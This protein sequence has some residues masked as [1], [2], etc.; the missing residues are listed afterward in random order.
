MDSALDEDALLACLPTPERLRDLAEGASL[1]LEAP[2]C[3]PIRSARMTLCHLAASVLGA[4]RYETMSDG[5]SRRIYLTRKPTGVTGGDL[6]PMPL[7]MA[8]AVVRATVKREAEDAEAARFKLEARRQRRRE[9]DR[10]REAERVERQAAAR[11]SFKAAASIHAEAVEAAAKVE[12]EARARAAEAA[13]AER[14]RRRR[15]NP[16]PESVRQWEMG[17]AR[18]ILQ[19][20]REHGHRGVVLVVAPSSSLEALRW[21]FQASRPGTVEIMDHGE[22]ARIRQRP[23][24]AALLLWP[25]AAAADGDGFGPFQESLDSSAARLIV[26]RIS[27]GSPTAASLHISRFQDRPPPA[28]LPAQA[29]DTEDDL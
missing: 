25:A 16:A 18:R 19:A 13:A 12:E 28:F 3:V 24:V 9:R 2:R 14:E 6:R 7:A 21:L 8:A 10:A 4:G 20:V 27:G 1:M 5:K 11:A 17:A 22:A 26:T 23:D 15:L 29:T